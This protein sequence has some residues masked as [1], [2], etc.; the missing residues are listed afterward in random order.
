MKTNTILFYAFDNHYSSG[1]DNKLRFNDSVT[2]QNNV[3]QGDL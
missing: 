1:L 3:M 2:D